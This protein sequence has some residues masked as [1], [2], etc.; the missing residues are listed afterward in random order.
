MKQITL[1]AL[2]VSLLVL[3]SP[4]FAEN[5][6]DGSSLTPTARPCGPGNFAASDYTYAQFTPQHTGECICPPMPGAAQRGCGGHDETGCGLDLCH[7]IRYDA[8]TGEIIEEGDES[9]IWQP[10]GF[11]P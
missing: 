1:I 5:R 4:L 11:A 2:A 9:C 8:E 6:A 10:Y 7:Y 3:P